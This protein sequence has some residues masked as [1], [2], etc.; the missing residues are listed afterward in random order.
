MAINRSVRCF[1]F[2][3]EKLKYINPEK[4]LCRKW[5]LLEDRLLTPGHILL[6]IVVM[7]EEV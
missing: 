5:K 1:K 6:Y 2:V 7:V 4:F 3:A